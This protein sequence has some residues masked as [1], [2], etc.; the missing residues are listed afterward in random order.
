MKG[1][2]KFERTLI[3]TLHEC[4]SYCQRN[5]LC[6]YFEWARDPVNH[7]SHKC[8]LF[9]DYDYL[10]DV[11]PGLE[12]AP[13]ITGPKWCDSVPVAKQ[14]PLGG[15]VNPYENKPFLHDNKRHCDTGMYETGAIG[16]VIEE[17]GGILP[18]ECFLKCRQNPVST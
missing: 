10:T 2:V 4:Q 17:I 7:Y 8:T 14:I 13:S 1:S 6:Y 9:G 15:A 11:A 3:Y 12:T 5:L 18:T 16:K